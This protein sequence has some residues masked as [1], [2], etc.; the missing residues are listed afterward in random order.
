[1]SMNYMYILV[2]LWI[3]ANIQQPSPEAR[4]SP[5]AL[6]PLASALIF[7]HLALPEWRHRQDVRRKRLQYWVE[8]GSDSISKVLWRSWSLYWDTLGWY[9]DLRF[10]QV[11]FIPTK[12]YILN[13]GTKGYGTSPNCL[14]VLFCPQS[15]KGRLFDR[16]LSEPNGEKFSNQMNRGFHTAIGNYWTFLSKHSHDIALSIFSIL[17]S[18]FLL[19]PMVMAGV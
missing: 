8:R 12:Q 14:G 15:R 11:V 18:L 3:S 17:R 4:G 9:L 6:F 5:L 10:E 1:M 19:Y 16:A 2:H 7:G 13:S